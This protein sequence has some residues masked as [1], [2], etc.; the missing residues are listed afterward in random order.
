MNLVATWSSPVAGNYQLKLTV[1]DN[2]GLSATAV[3][4]I[5][6]TAK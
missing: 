3:V 2:T 5:V 1:V 6:I 4:P